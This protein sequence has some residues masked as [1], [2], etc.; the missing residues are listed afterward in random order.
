MK[1]YNAKRFNESVEKLALLYSKYNRVVMDDNMKTRPRYEEVKEE[2]L[3]SA[4]NLLEGIDTDAIVEELEEYLDSDLKRNQTV[5][6]ICDKTLSEGM[7]WLGLFREK[8]V[9]MFDCIP[10]TF[11]RY[12]NELWTPKEFCRY[13]ALTTRKK[14]RS[15]QN[16][17]E[18]L[19]DV[20]GIASDTQ[21]CGTLSMN[22]KKKVSNFS[23]IIQYEDKERLL[24]RLHELID[25]R[26]G[27][28]VGSVILQAWQ[29][30]L[31]TRK[32]TRKEFESEFKTKGCWTAIY[33]YLDD[34]NPNALSRANRII[35]ID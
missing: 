14:A 30:N 10:F 2:D 9:S 15:V 28:D 8:D 6:N 16:K 12:T 11:K 32:P 17:I 19:K 33:K 5:F 34:N 25:G 1:W 23:D 7:C 27:A 35:I 31:I 18:C 13:V 26:G 22:D 24:K 29:T 3:K 4:S 20:Y 21:S